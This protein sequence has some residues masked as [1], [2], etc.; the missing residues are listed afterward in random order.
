MTNKISHSR[1]SPTKKEETS[2]GNSTQNY[3]VDDATV[4]SEVEDRL[5][6]FE[7]PP[8]AHNSN[9]FSLPPQKSTSSALEK[10]IFIGRLTKSVEVGGVT[11]EISSLTNKEHGD[12]IRAMYRFSEAA[13]LFTIRVLTLANALKKIDG[14]PIDDIDIGDI[15]DFEDS[16]H[17]RM[18]IIDSLQL[19]VVEKLFDEYEDLVKEEEDVSD[20]NGDLKNS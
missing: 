10:L 2:G 19:S 5:A 13:D 1:M 12:V 14:M 9:S 16:Y 6:Q 17:R 20:Q 8:E 18:S 3:V 15:E 4:P 11:F 7:A